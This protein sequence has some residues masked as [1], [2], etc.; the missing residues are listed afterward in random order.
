MLSRKALAIASLRTIVC[1]QVVFTA[2]FTTP[3]IAADVLTTKKFLDWSPEA[4][5]NFI[6]TTTMMGGLIAAKNREGQAECI[7]AWNAT[8]QNDGF[9]PVI[10]AMKKL[11]DYHPLAIVSAVIE[12]ACGDFKYTTKAAALP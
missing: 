8:H 2:I 1:S 11:P 3:A 12:K 10:D 9:K 6:I 7:D 5:R 4:Q